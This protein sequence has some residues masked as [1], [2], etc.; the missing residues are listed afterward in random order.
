MSFCLL[1]SEREAEAEALRRRMRGGGDGEEA[2][3]TG[4]SR[5]RR[6]L[7]EGAAEARREYEECLLKLQV[8]YASRF[9][10]L[11]AKHLNKILFSFFRR[12]RWATAGRKRSKKHTCYYLLIFYIICLATQGGLRRKVLLCQ[13]DPP[14]RSGAEEVGLQVSFK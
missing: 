14:L 6:K 9:P 3:E 8:F 11:N 12:P 7:E 5:R 1:G 4:L 2:S 13:V 10:K